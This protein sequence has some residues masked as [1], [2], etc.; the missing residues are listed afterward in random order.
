MKLIFTAIIYR[1]RVGFCCGHVGG[2]QPPS[3]DAAEGNEPP[4]NPRPGPHLLRPRRSSLRA[5]LLQQQEHRSIFG[6]RL[7]FAVVVR[8]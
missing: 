1:R 5:P 6:L 8:D 7:P 4:P 2:V 3:E